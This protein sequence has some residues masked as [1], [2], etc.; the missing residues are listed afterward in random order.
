MGFSKI[1]YL[2]KPNVLLWGAKSTAR[3]V[4]KM[5][6]DNKIGNVKLIYD[7]SIDQ[8]TF[9]SN[10]LFI[11]TNQNLLIHINKV[12]KFFVCIGSEHGFARSKISEILLNFGLK[13]FNIIHKN[14]FID[15]T[16]EIGTGCLIMPFA[17]VHKF[18]SIGN[19]VYIN[20][21]A[22]IDHE[23]IIGN[24][25]HIM[26]NAAIAGK[27]R[28]GANATIGT[29]ATILPNLEI[30]EGSF[31]GAGAVVTKNVPPFSV[32]AGVPARFIKNTKEFDANIF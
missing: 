24:G 19:Y 3:I 15:P 13:S 12:S 27:V 28:I 22:S 21:A 17:L 8:P 9:S 26:G 6:F 25:V 18:T 14:S 1:D 29:N 4:E 2:F 5:I 32:Y 11:N 31:I 10:A 7:T 30:G 20:S 16:S 23:C